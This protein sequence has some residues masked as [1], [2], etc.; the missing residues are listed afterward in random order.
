[1][2][3]AISDLLDVYKRAT[4]R[5]FT[6][7]GLIFTV[8][9]ILIFAI[10]NLVDFDFPFSGGNIKLFVFNPFNLLIAI[11]SS[12]LTMSI[13]WFVGT[14]YAPKIGEFLT[15]KK[16]GNMI[17]TK[18]D[19]HY[20]EK[21]ELEDLRIVPG[22]V[23]AKFINL[24]MSYLAITA[25][26]LG[27]FLGFFNGT[28]ST[29]KLITFFE[30]NLSNDPV[31]YVLKLI[32]VFV[33][34]PLLLTLTIPIPWMLID[35]KLKAYNSKLKINSLVGKSI[36]K[37][38]TPIFAI[39]GLAT[40][41]LQN[42]TPDVIILFLTFIFIFLAF[43]SILMVTLYNM[44]FQVKYYES[45]LRSIP[46]PYGT[47]KVEMELKFKKTEDESSNRED[48]VLETNDSNLEDKES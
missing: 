41:L 22:I 7:P 12:V 43:P 13:W 1:M 45:I 48:Q 30:S 14:R 42:L 10:F 24:L 46:V 17:F 38:L 19:I 16:I 5:V 47:T 9:L 4:L 33:L 6:T 3:N 18:G 32:L 34:A 27:I 2:S 37:L 35:T 21:V 26:L 25:F 36:Q 23:I 20:F 31:A 28:D 44:I 11:V 15:E 39:G 40:L 8:I 29:A